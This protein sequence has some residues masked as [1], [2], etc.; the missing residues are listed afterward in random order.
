[1]KKKHGGSMNKPKSRKYTAHLAFICSKVPIVGEL[2][3]CVWF[4]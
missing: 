2:F 1:M 3:E 4:A